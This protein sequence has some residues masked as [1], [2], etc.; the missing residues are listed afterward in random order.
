MDANQIF[1]D[2]RTEA[3]PCGRIFDPVLGAYL[4]GDVKVPVDVLLRIE[5]I[6]FEQKCRKLHGGVISLFG[7]YAVRVRM[8]ELYSDCVRIG[9][10][11][12]PLLDAVTIEDGACVVCDLIF[13]DTLNNGAVKVYDVVSGSKAAAVR[14]IFKAFKIIAVLNRRASCV[15]RPMN[16]DA[17]NGINVPPGAGKLV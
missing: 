7:E 8:A 2:V 5:C 4:S 16:D 6:F 17:S 15:S 12:Q 14:L 1:F 9:I 10:A 13:G 11:A 3:F